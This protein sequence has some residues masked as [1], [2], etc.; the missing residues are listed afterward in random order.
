MNH[1]DLVDNL[2]FIME[3]NGIYAAGS[4]NEM[5]GNDERDY[6]PFFTSGAS[7]L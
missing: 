2:S 6:N 1:D 7:F 5:K 4:K 3:P